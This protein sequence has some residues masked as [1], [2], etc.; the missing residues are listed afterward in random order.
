MEGVTVLPVGIGANAGRGELGVM[1]LRDLS[2]LRT[3]T[4]ALRSLLPGLRIIIREEVAVLDPASLVREMGEISHPFRLIVDAP[5]LE[6]EILTGLRAAGAL[7]LIDQ[8]ELRC[9][10]EIFFEGGSSRPELERW[11]LEQ[12]FALDHID[13]VDPEWPVL[14]LHADHKA[15][16]ITELREEKGTLEHGLRERDGLIADLESR[17]ADARATT[18]ACTSELA[19]AGNQLNSLTERN[20]ALDRIVLDLREGQDAL[21]RELGDTNERMADLQR[22]L[23]DARAETRARTAELTAAGN[24]L[25]SLTEGNAALDRMILDL[26]ESQDALK[27]ELGDKNARTANLQRRLADAQAETKAR[28][29]ELAEAGNQLNSLTERNAA[30]DKTIAQLRSEKDSAEDDF[31][32]TNLDLRRARADLRIAL[33]HQD[34]LQAELLDLQGRFASERSVRQDQA[35]LLRRLTP[36]LREAARQL[37]SFSPSETVPALPTKRA[38]ADRK[39]KRA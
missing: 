39:V 34:R 1:N 9:G 32:R 22:G 30:L 27:Q 12:S 2:S 28:T 25:S 23:A 19:E 20:T 8:L 29:A 33:R 13:R 37:Q 15:R 24:R 21:R 3:P 16:T 14:H 26:R 38:A 6:M 4:D 35:D 31:Q 5:G 17:L 36:R 10:E 11:L 7:E 18:E